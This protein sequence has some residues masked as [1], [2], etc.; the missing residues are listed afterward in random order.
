[1]KPGIGTADSFYTI[2]WR[3]KFAIGGGDSYDVFN[4]KIFLQEIERKTDI[5]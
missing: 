2:Y 5:T 3:N 1:M 4:G